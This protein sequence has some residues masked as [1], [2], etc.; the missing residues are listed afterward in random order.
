MLLSS[1]C[2]CQSA[3]EGPHAASCDATQIERVDPRPA[4]EPPEWAPEE[5]PPW[6]SPGSLE[7]RPDGTSFLSLFRLPWDYGHRQLYPI[8]SGGKVYL[9]VRYLVGTGYSDPLSARLIVFVD[10]KVTPFDRADGETVRVQRTPLHDGRGEASISLPAE[11]FSPGLS[12][13]HVFVRVQAGSG[14]QPG[15]AFYDFT[16]QKGSYQIHEF[17]ETSGYEP[18]SHHVSQGITRAYWEDT[19]H[20]REWQLVYSASLPNPRGPLPVTLRVQAYH[21]F[22]CPH[23]EDQ[24]AI[25]ALLDGERVPLAGHDEIFAKMAKGEQREFR[26]DL[27]LPRDGREHLYELVYL[28]SLGYPTRGPDGHPG[29]WNQGPSVVSYIHWGL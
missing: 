18:V 14:W 11:R 8:A 21:E 6:L 19:A 24:F 9:R 7:R 23:L 10:G 5:L 22:A 1:A 17:A 28:P 16:V 12:T 4:D 27:D 25:V 26:Y 3:V 20:D 2:S 13:V 15:T 29:G